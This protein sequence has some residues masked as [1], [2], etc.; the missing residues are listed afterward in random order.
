[1]S[2][3]APRALGF[4]LIELIIVLAVAAVLLGIAVPSFRTFNQ[5]SRLTTQANSLVYALNLARS[6][7]VS[8]DQ[9]VQVCASSDGATCTGTWVQGW[10]VCYPVAACA[11]GG[12]TLLLVSPAL[13]GGNTLTEQIGGALAVTYLT[14]GQTSSGPGGAAYRFAFCDS[15]GATFA[16]DVEINP[17]GRIESGPTQGQTVS[18]AAL[19]CP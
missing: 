10:I 7:A 11:G 3:Y 17:I 15:R 9:K 5:N 14:S 13:G 2:N 1:M 4:S 12:A 16:Q 6:E 18:G 8:L 19:A